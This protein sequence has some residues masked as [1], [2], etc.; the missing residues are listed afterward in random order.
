MAR[1]IFRGRQ[2]SENGWP[3]VDQGSC[4]WFQVAPGVS[5]QIQEGLPFAI[6]GAFARDYHA[7][8]EPIFDPDCA[9][10][11]P[12][13]SVATSNHPGGTALDIRWNSHPFQKRGSFNAAQLRTIQELLDFYE[14]TV[15]WAG[16][17]W[18]EGGWGSPIDE[19]HWQMGYDTYDQALDRPK[20]WV[21]DFAA[22][23]IRAD[24][25]STFRRGNAPTAD[26][27]ALILSQATGLSLQKATEIL[28]AL[29]DGLVAAECT[30]VNRIA[31]YLAQVGHES[32][33]FQYTEEIA[34]NGRYAPYI[35]RTWIQITWDYNYRAFSEWCFERGL[36]SAPD[37]FVTNYRELADLKWAGIGAAWYWTVARGTRINDAADR[38]D[39]YTTTQLINGGQ[40]GSADRAARYERA[41]SI[42]DRLLALVSTLTPT[43]PFEEALLMEVESLSIYADPGEPKIPVYK[44][45]QALDAH[46]PHEPYV[47][48]TAREGVRDSV[49]RVVRT[50][51]GKGKY[52]TDALAVN[53]ASKVLK[54]LEDS[55]VLAAYL[56]GA[57]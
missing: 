45:I 31:M 49:R 14:G 5:M 42:G 4:K 34:K 28:P 22:R 47:E 40:N 6:L 13:N 20:Q 48:K 7:Y 19:M 3:Y 29:R 53:Q 51:A 43:D 8:I 21:V 38:R 18:S 33:S 10:W 27:P 30:T 37:Y 35:G 16:I 52:G 44:M 15:F 57:A 36:V 2:F 17:D 11:T 54:E 12:D 50:A 23:K 9:S 24:G 46:G 56:K 39:L 25:N 1:R 55:G 26:D 32:V 41:L